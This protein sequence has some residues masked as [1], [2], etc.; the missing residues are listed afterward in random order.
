VEF[1]S[2]SKDSLDAFAGLGYDRFPVC[3]AKTPF[4]LSHEASRRGLPHEFTLPV[5][6]IRVAAGAGFF[7]VLCGDSTLLPG[8]PSVP[9]SERVELDVESGQI[10]GLS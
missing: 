2:E 1:S 8:L 4:S 6:E 9:N 7:T 3:L 5:R 10:L